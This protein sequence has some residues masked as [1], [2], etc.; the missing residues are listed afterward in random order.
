MLSWFSYLLWCINLVEAAD[1]I[2]VPLFPIE[3][4]PT[5]N[6]LRSNLAKRA[7]GYAPLIDHV[8]FQG[9]NVDVAYLGSVSIGTPPQSFLVGISLKCEA[10]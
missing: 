3:R 5:Q 4:N 7:I 9:V 8:S 1:L 6:N 10:E 2:K